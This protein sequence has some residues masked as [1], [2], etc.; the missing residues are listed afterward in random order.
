MCESAFSSMP[1]S[2]TANRIPK[3][4]SCSATGRVVRRS[5]GRPTPK[6]RRSRTSKPFLK[7]LQTRYGNILVHCGQEDCWREGQHKT[8]GR[9]GMPTGVT[10]NDQGQAS[11]HAEQR[12]R[13]LRAQIHII[14]EDLRRTGVEVIFDHPAGRHAEW[15]LN[16]FVKSD[17]RLSGGGTIKTP[18]HE[19]HTGDKAPSNVARFL[20]WV[21]VRSR[22]NDDKQ[23]RFLIGWS[24]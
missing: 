16:F 6:V 18:P 19:A 9:L 24:L 14:V 10:T 4:K 3:R 13:A 21:L 7:V 11:G 17:V 5:Q 15:I 22:T 20:K 8:A 1:Q 12:V 2:R 23:S